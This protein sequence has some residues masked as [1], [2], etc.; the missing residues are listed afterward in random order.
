MTN[1]LCLLVFDLSSHTLSLENLDSAII[2][3]VIYLS[4]LLILDIKPITFPKTDGNYA[5]GSCLCFR[6]QLSSYLSLDS[7]LGF[8]IK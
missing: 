1:F 2:P 3:K 8:N 6:D 5:C 4:R 7:P